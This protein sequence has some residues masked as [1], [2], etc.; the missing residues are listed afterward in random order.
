VSELRQHSGQVRNCDY[1][2][3]SLA[4]IVITV[5]P[6][7]RCK[8]AVYCETSCLIFVPHDSSSHNC[9]AVVN[10]FD[11]NSQFSNYNIS[12][13]CIIDS[14]KPSSQLHPLDK[15][16]SASVIKKNI[17]VWVSKHRVNGQKM[18]HVCYM[19]LWLSVDL[20]P[21]TT[22]NWHSMDIPVDIQLTFNAWSTVGRK[23][24]ECPTESHASI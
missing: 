12:R 3:I 22:C 8:A 5:T 1:K 2:Y 18:D 17:N 10:C 13:A 23:C 21:Q 15:S 16:G 24:S 20:Y 4:K 7:V 19:H 9:F 14:I 6:V 11:Y